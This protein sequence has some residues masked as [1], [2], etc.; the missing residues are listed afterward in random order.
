VP[1]RSRVSSAAAARWSS[2]ERPEPTVRTAATRSTPVMSLITKPAGAGQERVHHRLLVGV[3]GEHQALQAGQQG[4]Q[5]AAHLDAVAVQQ[6]HVHHR[7]VRVQRRHPCHRLRG[8]GRRTDHRQVIG[9]VEQIGHPPPHHLVVVHHEHREH[10][11]R[12]CRV[13]LAR[14]GMQQGW[15][16]GSRRSRCEALA[17]LGAEICLYGDAAIGGGT[18]PWRL[19]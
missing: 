16:G 10:C 2:S 14:R 13:R 7:D 4:P 8:G 1:V 5:L 18:A 17:D 9:L 12:R 15:H 19:R 6:T 11:R 3:R